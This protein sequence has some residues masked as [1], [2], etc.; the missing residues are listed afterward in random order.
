[1]NF[2][3]A[4]NLLEVEVNEELT[5]TEEG[6]EGLG[7]VSVV[8]VHTTEGELDELHTMRYILFYFVLIWKG[9]FRNAD[10]AI[11]INLRFIKL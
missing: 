5:D 8:H 10:N 9:V 3:N 1:M 7:N 11:N 2:L 4:Q 6:E